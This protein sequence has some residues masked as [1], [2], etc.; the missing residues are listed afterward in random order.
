MTRRLAPA[1]LA[2]AL[3]TVLPGCAWTLPQNLAFWR[4]NADATATGTD[5]EAEAQAVSPIEDAVSPAAPGGYGVQPVG[6]SAPYGA[7]AVPGASPNAPGAQSGVSL[8]DVPGSGRSASASTA[9][10]SCAFG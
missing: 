8:Y 7:A 9:T 1:G 2:L 4:G 3:L 5:A 10:T 6:Y